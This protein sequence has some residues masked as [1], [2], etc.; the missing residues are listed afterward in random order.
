MVIA[1]CVLLYTYDVRD[2]VDIGP[3]RM[4]VI[5]AATDHRSALAGTTHVP[6][7]YYVT[8]ALEGAVVLGPSVLDQRVAEAHVVVK[9]LFELLHMPQ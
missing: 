9:L 8:K 6:T 5:I 3:I 1:S 2:Y 4:V 7:L